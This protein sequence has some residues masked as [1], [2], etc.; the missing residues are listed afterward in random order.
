MAWK[1]SRF[2]HQR[3]RENTSNRTRER[4]VCAMR[5]K[6]AYDDTESGRDI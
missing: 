2:A 4:N 6:H 1:Q 3:K 5:H